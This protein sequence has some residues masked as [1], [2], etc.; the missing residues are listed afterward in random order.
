MY[1][2][3]IAIGIVIIIAIGAFKV[4]GSLIK[5]LDEEMFPDSKKERSD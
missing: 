2:E 4:A 3:I 1:Q 5:H